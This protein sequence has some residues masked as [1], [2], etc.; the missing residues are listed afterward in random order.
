VDEKEERETGMEEVA[1]EAREEEEEGRLGGKWR[2]NG[3]EG[4]QEEGSVGRREG[5]WRKTGERKGMQE[6]EREETGCGEEGGKMEGDGCK[7]RKRRQGMGRRE[8]KTCGEGENILA[9]GH[10]IDIFQEITEWT[11]VVGYHPGC[12]YFLFL[13]RRKVE[14]GR[15]REKGRGRELGGEGGQGGEREERV[16]RTE[17]VEK[18]DSG[19]GGQREGRGRRGIH[20]FSLR[21]SVVSSR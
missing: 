19:G 16:G 2:E 5:R 7:K 12:R 4:M 3:G 1:R 10:V 17:E 18:A 14:G 11:F 21:S 8:I 15:H 13:V 9:H 6:E 20:R